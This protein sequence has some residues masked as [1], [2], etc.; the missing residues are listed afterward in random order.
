LQIS[1]KIIYHL[2]E[3]MMFGMSKQMDSMKRKTKRVTSRHTMR[4]TKKI[5]RIH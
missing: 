5:M 3:F 1:Q 2:Q 4:K